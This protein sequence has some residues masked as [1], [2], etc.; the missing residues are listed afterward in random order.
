MSVVAFEFDESAFGVSTLAAEIVV[1][2]GG[3]DFFA[4]GFV[5]SAAPLL[6]FGVDTDAAMTGD[7]F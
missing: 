6:E 3:Y 4:V 2:A 5:V 1:S 7:G